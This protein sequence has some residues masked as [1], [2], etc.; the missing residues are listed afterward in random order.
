M[1]GFPKADGPAKESWSQ[2]KD[3]LLSLCCVRYGFC[4]SFYTSL[5]YV[6]FLLMGEFSK[7]LYFFVTQFLQQAHSQKR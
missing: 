4:C 5:V 2:M 7:R 1:I 6:P 3:L